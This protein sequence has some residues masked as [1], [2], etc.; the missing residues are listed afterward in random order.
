[1]TTDELSLRKDITAAELPFV[2]SDPTELAATHRR[3]VEE[4]GCGEDLA[5]R[6]V[7]WLG[8]KA[9]GSD[10]GRSAPTRS[11][12]RKILTSLGPPKKTRRRRPQTG[13]IV[14][15]QLLTCLALLSSLALVRVHKRTPII[16]VGATC[17]RVVFEDLHFAL[18]IEAIEEDLWAWG[19]EVLAVES[20]AVSRLDPGPDLTCEGGEVARA[21]SSRSFGKRPLPSLARAA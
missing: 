11:Y 1:M 13:A 2:T 10:D 20:A 21:S 8:R 14:S 18:V 6:I 19:I 15:T 7:K 3:L 9:E 16:L 5:D 17:V 12:Y 4:A